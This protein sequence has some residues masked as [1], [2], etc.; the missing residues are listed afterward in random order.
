MPAVAL[1]ADALHR[2]AALRLRRSG[3]AGNGRSVTSIAAVTRSPGRQLR[4]ALA[5]FDDVAG[6]FVAEN[7][8]QLAERLAARQQVQV[9]AAQAARPYA[10]QH[11]AGARARDGARPSPQAIRRIARPPLRA[12]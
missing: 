2:A 10:D 1:E 11:L 4:D 3:S 9:G 7:A 5:Q 8:R 12:S 6:E